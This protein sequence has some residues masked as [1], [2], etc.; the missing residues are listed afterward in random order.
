MFLLIRLLEYT[1]DGYISAAIAK[2]SNY[3]RL[4]ESLAGS[5]L[6]AF[7]NGASDVITAL[8][9]SS[10][11]EGDNLV[12]GSLFGASIFT[13][14][15]CMGVIIIY[16]KKGFVSDL[17]EVRFPAIISCYL[18]TIAFLLAIGSYKVPYLYIGIVLLLIYI[19]YVAVIEIQER[20]TISE[21]VT[22]LRY[23]LT[24]LSS[25]DDD[26]EDQDNQNPQ[27]QALLPR[28]DPMSIGADEIEKQKKTIIDEI[29]KIKKKPRRKS[30]SFKMD[31][32]LTSITDIEPDAPD[33][34]KLMR[35]VNTQISSSWQEKNIL[36]KIVYFIEIV[37][38]F[39][40]RITMPPVDSQLLFKAQ[41]YIYPF[42]SIFFC[43]YSKDWVF[44]TLSISGKEVPFWAI[45][46]IAG[47]LLNVFVFFTTL[48]RYKPTPRVLFLAITTITGLFWLDYI[49]G[50]IVDILNFVQL[51]TNASD[52][53]LGM[54]MLGVGN[55]TIDMFVDYTLAKKGFE[56]M[57]ITG[58]FSGQ[59]FNLLVG[60][61]LSCVSRGIRDSTLYFHVFDWKT[62]LSDKEG[63]MVFVII[64]SCAFVL[65]SFSIL[66]PSTKY[67]FGKVIGYS[68]IAGYLLLLGGMTIV[69]IAWS[70]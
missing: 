60:F 63:F 61:G 8:V 50:I 12:M 24:K 62:L 42:T 41:Q 27:E 20:M 38:H 19:A 69:E 45:G 4:S 1:S 16:S 59:M 13:M 34:V 21:K 64:I 46:L 37:L 47:L 14:S 26:F 15:C 68:C 11:S 66:L 56:V 9:A 58:I 17:N 10:G 54:I 35:K 70:K 43:L 7:S 25:V 33:Y 18:I 57:A 55:S 29:K 67:K 65:V 39:F 36:M 44:E 30:G 28:I 51:W 23:Q 3:L 53:Y 2:I 48:S 32:W 5:T 31:E 22:A 49:V 52:L 40:V 6:L